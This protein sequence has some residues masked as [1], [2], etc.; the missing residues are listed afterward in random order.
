MDV[1]WD[2]SSRVHKM[3]KKNLL[4]SDREVSGIAY[5]RKQPPLIDHESE[6]HRCLVPRNS[7]ER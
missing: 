2:I 3:S 7:Q 1:Y 6:E 4:D 5:G